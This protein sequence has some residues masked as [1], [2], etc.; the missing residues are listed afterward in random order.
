MGF[1]FEVDSEHRVIWVNGKSVLRFDV[2]DPALEA[3][4]LQFRGSFSLQRIDE[5][6]MFPAIF[7]AG[8]SVNK[9]GTVTLPNTLAARRLL[10]YF[11]LAAPTALADDLALLGPLPSHRLFSEFA[12]L[13]HEWITRGLENALGRVRF[14]SLDIAREQNVLWPSSRLVL[15][16]QLVAASD[17]EALVAWREGRREFQNA[18]IRFLEGASQERREELCTEIGTTEKAALAFAFPQPSV[19]K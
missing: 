8:G 4:V 17:A 6:Q 2:A 13:P 16:A 12:S 18:L 3:A 19:P 1:K 14:G 9:D 11:A 10:N 7:E 5:L 15:R